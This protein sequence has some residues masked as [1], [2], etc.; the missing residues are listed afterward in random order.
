M[1]VLKSV[2]PYDSSRIVNYPQVTDMNLVVLLG[3][4]NTAFQSYKNSSFSERSHRMNKVA[5]ILL[6]RR[7]EFAELITREMGKPIKEAEAEVKKCSWVC[8][9][10]ASRAEAFL[11]DRIV[12]TEA[13]ESKVIYQ[14]LGPI[15]AIMPW[16]YPFW[17]VFR[18]AA[19]TLMAGNTAL[20]KHASNV[21]GCAMAI[22]DIFIQAGYEQG[23]FQNLAIGSD[24][25]AGVIANE[26]IKA[27]TL[28]GSEQAGVA[29]ATEAGRHLKKCVLELGGNNAFVVLNDANQELALNIALPAR[30]QNGGQ[31][32][33]AAKRFI[34]ESWIA[35]DFVPEL[36]KRVGQMEVGDPMEAD[37]Q[38]GATFISK[39]GP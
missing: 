8:E 9:F 2:N 35:E 28:T 30:L 24:R 20:L 10:Y 7:R 22:E 39:A 18:F 17:Q 27:V 23:A 1:P 3:R 15:L 6:E 5:S 26:Y 36:V 33:I 19:P 4:A 13:E 11:A 16:N 29:V 25:V 21:Q 32:C 12:E 37:T 38:V 14:P 34:I 31:S